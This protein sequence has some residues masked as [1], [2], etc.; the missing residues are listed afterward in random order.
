MAVGKTKAKTGLINLKIGGYLAYT[1]WDR[2]R[3]VPHWLLGVPHRL[4]GVPHRV[5]GDT[6]FIP[7]GTHSSWLLWERSRS[8]SFLRGQQ[9]IGR[10]AARRADIP[11]RTL[12][13]TPST[14]CSTPSTLC[15]TS[16]TL[17]STPSTLC[18]TP[19]T[20]CTTPITL[21]SYP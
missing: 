18:S 1:P 2:V 14:L 20:L 4:L 16:G 10:R 7:L 19:S 15:I 21:W 9:N 12:C 11:S 6:L 17:C 8:A 13:S 5:L 3:G